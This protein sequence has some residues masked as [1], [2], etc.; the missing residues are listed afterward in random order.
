V[1]PATGNS[2]FGGKWAGK[3]PGE[4]TTGI[5]PG[6]LGKRCKL[7]LWASVSEKVVVSGHALDL[8][9]LPERPYV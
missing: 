5:P 6:T 7:E 9:L 8:Q 1:D 4:A 2:Y 3:K